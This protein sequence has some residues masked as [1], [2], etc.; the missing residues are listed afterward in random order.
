MP[1]LLLSSL[2]LLLLV[3]RLLAALADDQVNWP[4]DPVTIFT[5]P[6]ILGSTLLAI[7][8]IEY[9]EK[10]S[11]ENSLYI[12]SCIFAFALGSNV[13]MFIRLGNNKHSRVTSPS[14]QHTLPSIGFLTTLAIMGIIGYAFKIH[15]NISETGIPLYRR[16]TPEGWAEARVLRRMIS[17][18]QGEGI[19]FAGLLSGLS[20]FF[21]A[22][23]ITHRSDE[24]LKPSW[25]R[26]KVLRNLTI[27]TVL[28]DGLI[29]N[30]GRLQ[31]VLLIML[32]AFSSLLVNLKKTR[33]KPPPAARNK[34]IMLPL[35]AGIISI[36]ITVA[37][38]TVFVKQR[39]GNADP[40][41]LLW[42]VHR[43]K[44]SGIVQDL[45]KN[46]EMIGYGALSLT[47]FT[48]PINTLSLYQDL[49]DWQ[50]PGPY[51]GQF[52]IRPFAGMIIRRFDDKLG[53]NWSQEFEAPLEKMGFGTGV[54]GTFLR[55]VALDTGRSGVPVAMLILGILARWAIQAAAG[56]RDSVLLLIGAAVLVCCSFS[57]FHSLLYIDPIKSVLI[58]GI[59]VISLR[60][61]FSSRPNSRNKTSVSPAATQG[62]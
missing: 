49:P 32:L 17:L 55:D 50:F 18:T 24:Q 54:W 34:K 57:S 3:H 51:L 58:T 10:I 46:N 25:K 23:A 11:L 8:G 13:A 28:F 9:L 35:G 30:G 42:W 14:T 33:I 6:W 22:F 48:A 2:L 43:A 4:T 40:E 53:R 44:L 62:G 27:F 41:N 1:L 15:G 47:Y 56:S 26:I 5:A 38:G 37:F 19:G 59:C 60:R 21:L 29:I 12:F 7:P 52:N 45:A 36:A 16:F 31:L 61:L 39:V 20:F